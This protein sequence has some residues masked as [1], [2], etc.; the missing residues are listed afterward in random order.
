MPPFRLGYLTWNS[1][2]GLFF[3]IPLGYLLVRGIDFGG[4]FFENA[5]NSRT[6]E[7]LRKT[8]F[9]GVGVTLSTIV[10]GVGLAWVT[11]RSN[12]YGRKI[13]S[14]LA[15]LPLAFPSFVG[16]VALILGFSK[17]GLVEK[18]SS[19]IGI[20]SLPSIQGYWGAWFALTLFTYP[21]VYLPTRARF[22]NM[23]ESQEESALLLGK[24]QVNIFFTIVL[25]QAVRSI[26]SGAL[27]VF[28]YTISDFG[29][30]ALLRY[31]TLTQSIFSNRLANQTAS[32]SQAILLVLV[33]L[34]VVG[35]ERYLTRKQNDPPYSVT[36]RVAAP[37]PLG[38]YRLLVTFLAF[39]FFV[40][41]L[42]GPLL[43]MGFWVIRGIINRGNVLGP[44][45]I[46]F[47]GLLE[48]TLNTIY[49]GLIAGVVAMVLVF[50][51]AKFAIH[52]KSKIGKTISG[53]L[54]ASFGLP[55]LIIALAMI[56][57]VLEAPTSNL[58]ASWLYQTFPLMIA[59]YVIHFGAQAMGSAEVAVANTPK[60]LGEASQTLGAGRFRRLFSVELPIMAPTLAT[61]VGLV[62]L[63][64]MKEL[65]ITL[66]L[67]PI[68][69]STLATDIWSATEE[70]AL[71]Q[72]GL[73]SLILV[74]VSGILS[75][76]V[77]FRA[78]RIK[79]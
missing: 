40:I 26:S 72:T 49:A 53:I 48:P 34:M 52:H 75:W 31:N 61:G 3:L 29:A 77:L 41:S 16:A 28:L 46:H 12:I 36:H 62:M 30:V 70:R 78:Q 38:K 51:I 23:Q 44:L 19:S 24:N 5:F 42:V 56:F 65:P 45:A 71:A 8:I 22:L 76:F 54:S 10:V 69:F 2:V 13:L 15:P 68:G 79:Y 43:V 66:L 55:G 1:L 14:I 67:S 37:I 25:P 32:I 17:G 20:E 47:D 74:G 39:G 59:A 11:A 60:H 18:I 7:S 73:V 6:L 9:L 27:L 64:T 4:E 35:G 58:L 21:Y 50:P 57:W 33:G 63:S